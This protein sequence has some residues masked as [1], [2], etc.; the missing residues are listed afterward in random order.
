MID[1]VQP[2]AQSALAAYFSFDN[3]Q[4]GQPIH[5]S[6]VYAALQA[7]DGIVAADITLLRYKSPADQA[8]HGATSDLV[9]DHLKIDADELAWID[10]PETD[11]ALSAGWS[12][13]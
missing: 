2:S 10:D 3:L 4:F 11:I 7:V 12:P 13:T 9:Q 6:G 8:T 5:L 1:D